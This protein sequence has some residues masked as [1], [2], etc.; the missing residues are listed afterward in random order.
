MDGW[1]LMLLDCKMEWIWCVWYQLNIILWW[2]E[3]LSLSPLH[4][5]QITSDNIRSHQITSDH[6]TSHHMVI[7]VIISCDSNNNVLV[8][9]WNCIQLIEWMEYISI[10]SFDSK[11]NITLIYYITLHCVCNGLSYFPM[12]LPLQ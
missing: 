6:I 4:F 2:F 3:S 10:N 12:N 5:P 11:N 8:Y 1:M 9:H 7:L